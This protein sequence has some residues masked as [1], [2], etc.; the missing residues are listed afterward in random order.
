MRGRRAKLA[1]GQDRPPRIV[2]VVRGLGLGGAETLLYQR[3]KYAIETGLIRAADTT[4]I[5]TYPDQ[6]Y[7][8]ERIGKLGVAIHNT[9]S[10]NRLLSSMNL[11]RS[12]Q[13]MDGDRVVV[14]HSPFPAAVI[15]ARTALKRL[16]FPIVEVSHSTRY[17][18]PTLALGKA[19]NRYVD[20]CIA[21]S[22]DVAAAPTTTG[23]PR[24]SVILAGADRSSMR[25]WVL[26]S[27]DTAK[28]MRESIGVVGDAPLVVAVGS[29]TAG[30]GHRHLISA[31]AELGDPG[32]HVAIIGTGEEQSA[33]E[34]Q[35]RSLGLEDQAHLLGRQDDAWRWTAV[36]DALAHPSYHE[37]LPVALIEARVLN[38]PIVASD[39]GGAAQ[40]LAG[41][42]RSQLVEPGDN[43]GLAQ[44][45]RDV[46]KNVRPFSEVFPDRATEL[47]PWDMSRYAGEFYEA[48]MPDG[49]QALR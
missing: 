18:K 47:T 12:I 46:L 15:K 1:P 39:V 17:A 21:V 14:V 35:I 4:V 43:S 42:A 41:S 31:L 22:D 16:P 32:V 7:F 30:K 37:G 13:R 48:L 25:R 6:S 28:Q 5:N 24:K 49:V 44:A 33:L 40:V 19:L 29:L 27:C 11:W 9:P 8:A 23:F 36:A 20:L 38:V 26:A 10:S 34:Q 45:V 3:L 2:E